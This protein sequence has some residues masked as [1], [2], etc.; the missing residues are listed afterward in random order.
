MS[1]VKCNNCLDVI[2]S[3]HIFDHVS[4]SCWETWLDGGDELLRGG[5]CFKFI[6][7]SN[8]DEDFWEIAKRFTDFDK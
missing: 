3:K 7:K 2:E 4:C 6:K 1:K 8:I 5:G